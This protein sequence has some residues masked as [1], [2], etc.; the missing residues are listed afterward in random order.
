[1]RESQISIW[2][3][4]RSCHTGIVLGAQPHRAMGCGMD[5]MSDVETC[6]TKKRYCVDDVLSK[7]DMEMTRERSREP[8]HPSAATSALSSGKTNGRALDEVIVRAMG[9]VAAGAGR[10]RGAGCCA[11]RKSA[12][13]TRDCRSAQIRH[14]P[15]PRLRSSRRRRNIPRRA[16][17]AP[18]VIVASPPCFSPY[19][20][21]GGGNS[22][23]FA[24]AVT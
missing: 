6:T 14:Q 15:P 17:A 19:D 22:S 13:R 10:T 9:G 23:S 18:H 24:F 3:L 1:M 4:S 8:H 21:R 5:P 20:T 16:D 12:R 2:N 7:L 11:R